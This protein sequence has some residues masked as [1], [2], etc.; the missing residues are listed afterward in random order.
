MP[1]LIVCKRIHLV[2]LCVIG[3][4][5]Y[6]PPASAPQGL[7]L[8]V[9][10]TPYPTPQLIIE[11]CSSFVPVAVTNALMRNN[12]GTKRASLGLQFQRDKDPYGGE[13][14]AAGARHH[15]GSQNPYIEG[16]KSRQAVK[17]LSPPQFLQ[18]GSAS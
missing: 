9:L 18:L 4:L 7:V 16:K 17:P 13:C 14:R 6:N 5:I 8:Q 12:S 1:D 15:P 2:Q 3:E 11:I 10:Q